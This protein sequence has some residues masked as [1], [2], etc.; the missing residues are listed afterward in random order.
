L[1]IIT[2]EFAPRDEALEW[3][4]ELI[5]SD[6]FREHRV[7]ILTHSF[8]NTPGERIKKEG[9]KLTPCNWAEDVWQKLIYPSKN[10]CLVLSG[11]SGETPVIDDINN[12]N[13]Q[14][15]C[16]YRVDKSADGRDI[17]QMMFNAQQADGSWHGNGGDGWLRILEFMPDGKTIGVRTFSPLF[18]IS[19]ITKHLAWRTDS[20]DQYKIV[21]K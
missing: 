3:A 2:F 4:R 21:I 16:S 18:A 5:E 10:I 7:I 1:L 9:Y 20:Y 6:R 12:V 14:P 19:P 11:H 13:Y 15:T 8:L 17:P